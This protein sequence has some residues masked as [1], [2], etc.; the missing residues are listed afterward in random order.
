MEPVQLL[1]GLL[2]FGVF[3]GS[4]FAVTIGL[5]VFGRRRGYGDFHAPEIAR[6]AR[7]QWPLLCR[8]HVFHRW[9]TFRNRDDVRYQR[10]IG[11]GLTRD[12]PFIPPL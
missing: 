9:R 11:C 6:P 8:F 12:I 1:V 7:S 5:V 2:V 3:A 10:C 4:L